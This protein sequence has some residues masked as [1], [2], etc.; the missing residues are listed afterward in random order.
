MSSKKKTASKKARKEPTVPVSGYLE[1]ELGRRFLK[2]CADTGKSQSLV[3]NDAL[4]RALMPE[5]TDEDA[6]RMRKALDR[7]THQLQRYQRDTNGRLRL[8]TEL[9]GVFARSYLTHTPAVA[10]QHR[11]AASAS[12]R[13]RFEKMLNLVAESLGPG[14][15]ILECLPIDPAPG[16]P[17]SHTPGTLDTDSGAIPSGGAVDD[18]IEEGEP[19]VASS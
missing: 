8:L 10:P 14:R 12:G 6:E 2:Y 7:L 16:N 5:E 15:S 1:P 4:R 19:A 3:I 18:P 17:G 11:Q 9:V 13:Q